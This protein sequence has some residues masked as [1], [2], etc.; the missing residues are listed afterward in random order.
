MHHLWY[1]VVPSLQ[2]VRT[3]GI[4]HHTPY[5]IGRNMPQKEYYG[6][7]PPIELP[8]PKF[9]T[10]YSTML[11]SSARKNP[12]LFCEAATMARPWWLVQQASSLHLYYT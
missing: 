11:F 9:L 12:K 2:Y 8:K 3:E 7:Q 1:R 6:A 10:M 4:H 5:R